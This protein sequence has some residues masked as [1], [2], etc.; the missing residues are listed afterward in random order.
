MAHTIEDLPVP[1]GPIITFKL[2]PG[3]NSKESYVLEITRKI[4]IIH[5]QNNNLL[6]KL[7][8]IF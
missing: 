5:Q 6:I 3:L 4:R 7:H 1:L 8:K 2:A